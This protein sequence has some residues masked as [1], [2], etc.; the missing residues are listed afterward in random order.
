MAVPAA[1]EESSSDV[2]SIATVVLQQLSNGTITAPFN[3]QHWAQ[4]PEES[5]LLHMCKKIS[6]SPC[7]SSHTSSH[8][9]IISLALLPLQQALLEHVNWHV[10][11][12]IHLMHLLIDMPGL[13]FLLS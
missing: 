2:H 13:L 4:C 9:R 8:T 11:L 1:A 5:C 3:R 12:L 6:C 10:V 7:K